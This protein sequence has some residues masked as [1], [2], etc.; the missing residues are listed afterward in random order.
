M[1][2]KESREK[3]Y[4]CNFHKTW[5]ENGNDSDPSSGMLFIIVF[6][7]IA[8]I[9]S[10]L[11]LGCSWYHNITK[12]GYYDEKLYKDLEK[13]VVI[14][15]EEKDIEKLEKGVDS[16][17]ISYENGEATIEC[18]RIEE[19]CYAGVITTVKIKTFSDF[20]V[21]KQKRYTKSE[22]DY[23]KNRIWAWVLFIALFII[24]GAI[25]C[26]I[27]SAILRLIIK[28]ASIISY[29][30]KCRD[31]KIEAKKQKEMA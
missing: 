24:A 11:V 10:C 22:K 3:R 4:F 18:T 6:F 1:K 25:I 31:E 21:L 27:L 29:W 16:L 26:I 2:N 5:F 23:R 14:C 20:E 13:F 15:I 17:A 19:H 28:I 9:I 12:D 8:S 30:H 7:A